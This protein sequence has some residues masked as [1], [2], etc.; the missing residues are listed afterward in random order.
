MNVSTLT[1]KVQI[2][3]KEKTFIWSEKSLFLWNSMCVIF[4]KPLLSD[5]SL[6]SSTQLMF[7]HPM[8]LRYIFILFSH[9]AY[10]TQVAIYRDI[11]LTKLCIHFL[12][13]ESLLG[14]SCLI[15][16]SATLCLPSTTVF[17]NCFELNFKPRLLT[18]SETRKVVFTRKFLWFR[19]CKIF[20]NKRRVINV[21]TTIGNKNATENFIPYSAL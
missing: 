6:R 17:D 15:C 1:S 11:F 3:L 2:C 12:F 9:Y 8:S 16:L 14:F 4:T 18:C 21:G 13:C 19:G 10:D 20:C 5:S 7:S